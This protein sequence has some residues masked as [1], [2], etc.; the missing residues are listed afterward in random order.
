MSTHH[1]LTPT[2]MFRSGWFLLERIHPSLG[3]MLFGIVLPLSLLP[4]LMLYYA[5]VYHGDAFAPGLADR[6]WTAIALVFFAGELATIAAMGAVIRWIARLNGFEASH[7]NS[8]LLAFAAPIPLWLSSLAL[9]VP[10]LF[11]AGSVGILALVLSCFIIY[12]GVAML[13]RVK[14]DIVAG[15]IAYGIIACGMMAWALLLAII[16]PLG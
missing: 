11:F 3:R 4:P 12:H 9:F 16:I 2:A 13:L 10:N 15:S 6:N 8:Y 14:E 7:T 5:G 1:H